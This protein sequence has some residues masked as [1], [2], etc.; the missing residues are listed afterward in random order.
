MRYWF[1]EW[2]APV[3][4]VIILTASIVL[5]GMPTVHM[6]VSNAWDFWGGG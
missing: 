6:I 2:V 5:I 1:E 4:L 3:V